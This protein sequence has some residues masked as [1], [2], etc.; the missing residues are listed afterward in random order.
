M[1]AAALRPMLA[2]DA[3]AVAHL[4]ATSWRSAYRGIFSDRF[5]DH[6]AAEER[7]QSWRERLQLNPSATDWGVVAEDA[8]GRMVGFAYVMPHHDPDWGHYID[9]LHVAPDCKG[10][11]VGRCLMQAVASQLPTTPPRPLHLWVLDANDAAKRFYAKLGAEF[12]DQRI[13]DSLAGEQHRVWRCVWR[14]PFP[15]FA[16]E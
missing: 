12:A 2:S 15:L 10:G 13:D 16:K 1:T 4:H 3:D 14:A 8:H 9:N 6:E 5:L 7:R 11:G